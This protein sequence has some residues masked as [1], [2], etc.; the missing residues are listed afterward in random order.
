M[1][2]LDDLRHEDAHGSAVLD[3]CFNCGSCAHIGK[4]KTL[5][6]PCYDD[7][8]DESPPREPA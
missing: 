1:T 5:C 8:P 3:C 6:G 7:W 4:V 2:I